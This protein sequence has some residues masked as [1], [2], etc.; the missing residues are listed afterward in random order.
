MGAL[1]ENV[2]GSHPRAQGEPNPDLEARTLR[3]VTL[4]LVPFLMVCYVIAWLNRINLSFAALQM[5]RDLGLTAAMYGLGAGLFFIT[6][7]LCEI[8]SNLMLHRLGARRWIARIMLSWGVV[9]MASAFVRGPASF[10]VVRLLLGAAEAGFY[11]GVLYFLTLWF[12]KAHRGRVLGLFLASIAITGIVGGPLSVAL[13]THLSGVGGLKGWQWM[14]LVEGAPAVILAP[15]VLLWL[16]DRPATASWLP[17]AERRWLQDRLDQEARAVTE[18][19]TI[20]PLRA[21]GDPRVILLA[22]TYFSN[23]CLINGI[24]FFLPQIIHGLGASTMQ[25]GLIVAIPNLLALIVLIWWGRRSDARNERYG[26]AAFANLVGGLGLLAAML[27]PDPVLKI[28]AIAVSYAATLAF[29]APFWAI[30]GGF[31]TAGAAAS[32]I[33]AI[34][35]FGVTGGFIAPLVI[36]RLHDVT[37]DFRMGLGVDAGVAILATAIFYLAGRRH[38]PTGTAP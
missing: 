16:K 23:V 33:A 38:A 24:T 11:P 17:D 9:A 4:R 34:S 22:F 14:Y 21:I 3:R 6:Y 18:V 37:G 19:K 35:A 1:A 31:L 36:G 30:P 27:I 15:L 12:P 29:T 32:G 5:N 10:Y 2:A 26:H 13:L 28:S 7:C 8:P 25:T 20:T